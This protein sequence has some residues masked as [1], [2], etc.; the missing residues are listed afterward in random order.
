MC[1]M[2]H[3]QVG[4]YDFPSHSEV[5][6]LANDG[7]KTTGTPTACTNSSIFGSKSTGNSTG[8]FDKVTEAT[9]MSNKSTSGSRSPFNTPPSSAMQSQ[10][11]GTHGDT[12]KSSGNGNVAANSVANVA[13]SVKPVSYARATP[14]D[15]KH[16]FLL[17]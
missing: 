7:S 4:P 8:N 10:K 14:N 5:T 13:A 16:P 11:F 1:F 6:G 2:R 9:G 17:C 3:T 12:S 15:P